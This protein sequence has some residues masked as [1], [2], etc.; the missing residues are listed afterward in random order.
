M[1]ILLVTMEMNIGGAET[2]IL[3]LAKTLKKKGNNVYVVSAGGSLVN[4]LEKSDIE[5]IIAPLKDKKINHII[6]SYKILKKLI[7]EKNIDIVHAHARIPGFICGLV[8]KNTKTHFVTTIHGIYRVN[9]LLKALTNWGERTLAVS[10]DIRKNAIYEYKLKEENVKLTVNG[11]DTERFKKKEIDKDE[12][13]K[14]KIDKDKIKIMHISRLDK[15][16][17]QVAE[18]L[19]SILPELNAESDKEIQLVIVGSGNNFE[20]VQNLAQNNNNIILTG[21][22]NDVDKLLNMADIFVGVSRAA[23]EAMACELPVILVGNKSYMQGY[24]GIFTKDML[25]ESKKNNFTAR[26]YNDID[27]DKLKADIK[28]L[29]KEKNVE[30]GKYNRRVVEEN[31]SIQKMAEDALNIYKFNN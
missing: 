23:L 10:E 12:A 17:T 24:Q 31:Y 25:E 2:H 28:E 1:N 22:R 5:H 21:A 15:E 18:T 30:M 16:S 27:K 4:E 7:I 8:C 9:F 11:I 6:K 3:E 19:I 26:G 14:L 13:L 20:A 29:I